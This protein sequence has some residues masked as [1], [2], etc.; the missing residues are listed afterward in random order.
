MF[1]GGDTIWWDNFHPNHKR[2][3]SSLCR[4]LTA[5]MIVL[6]P[7]QKDTQ[8]KDTSKKHL[9]TVNVEMHKPFHPSDI[10]G[11]IRFSSNDDST[12]KLDKYGGVEAMG[13]MEDGSFFW[14]QPDPE[15][16]PKLHT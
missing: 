2:A 9:A 12:Y 6:N 5:A 3:S 10:K 11:A 8:K 15:K 4:K 7:S 14:H 16:R 13:L 1:V